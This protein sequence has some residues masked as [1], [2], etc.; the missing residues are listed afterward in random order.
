MLPG[1]VLPALLLGIWD[2]PLSN[3]FG[4]G[5]EAVCL[6]GGTLL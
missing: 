2:G 3:I 5:G 4:G 1:V 6:E